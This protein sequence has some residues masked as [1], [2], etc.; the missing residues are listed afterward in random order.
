MFKLILSFT[1]FSVV[2]SSTFADSALD[3]R[4]VMDEKAKCGISGKKARRY[5]KGSMT[6]R[7]V[8]DG[9]H[10]FFG[11]LTL[12]KKPVRMTFDISDLSQNNTFT[13]TFI[14]GDVVKKITLGKLSTSGNLYLVFEDS[15]NKYCD[16]GLVVTTL[17]KI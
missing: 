13:S 2:M 17:G 1:L 14:D 10:M 11:Y 7:V 5:N 15:E 3:G 8:I 6:R 16:S 4:W 9:N 12:D